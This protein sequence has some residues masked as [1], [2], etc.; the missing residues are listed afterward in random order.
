[1]KPRKLRANSQVVSCLTSVGETNRCVYSVRYKMSW[2]TFVWRNLHDSITHNRHNITTQQHD[3]TSA[4]SLP[5][6]RGIGWNWKSLTDFHGFSSEH[7]NEWMCFPAK[8][9]FTS[10]WCYYVA[11]WW[12]QAK[13]SASVYWHSSFRLYYDVICNLTYLSL[14]I[15]NRKF[16]KL[17]QIILVSQ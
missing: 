6:Q 4:T 13:R 8:D 17:T 10:S 5:F 7:M 11:L 12:M 3:T 9:E 16:S 15:E 2:K 1:M 14:M